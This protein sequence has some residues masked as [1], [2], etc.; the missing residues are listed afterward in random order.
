MHQNILKFM[1]FAMPLIRFTE[2]FYICVR[3]QTILSL[4][5]YSLKKLTIARLELCGAILLAEMTVSTLQSV[6]G[7][8]IFDLIRL[9]CDSQIALCWL[10]SPYSRWQTFIAN[11]VKK[12][13]NFAMGRSLGLYKYRRKSS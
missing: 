7:L 13:S 4:Q 3:F 9:W 11:G 10:S 8:K 6:D 5:N 1:A 2:L 12:N